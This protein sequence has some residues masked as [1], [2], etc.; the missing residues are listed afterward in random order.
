MKNLKVDQSV[1]I[2]CGACMSIDPK[3]FGYSADGLSEAKTDV[4]T[5][6][7]T[8]V[9]AAAESCPTGAITLTDAEEKNEE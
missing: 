7:N 4:V 8:D 6:D 2:R 5:D 9:V 3:D 1:C